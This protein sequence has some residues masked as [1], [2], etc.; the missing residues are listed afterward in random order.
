MLC[1]EG[2]VGNKK[3]LDVSSGL[4]DCIGSSR[5]YLNMLASQRVS[6]EWETRCKTTKQVVLNTSLAEGAD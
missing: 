2:I 4:V 6:T 1:V 3:I 5:Q